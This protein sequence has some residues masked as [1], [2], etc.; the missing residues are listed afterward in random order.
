MAGITPFDYAAAEL[1]IAAKYGKF[2]YNPK[3]GRM[4]TIMPTTLE[5]PSKPMS[6]ETKNYITL[7]QYN[8]NLQLITDGINRFVADGNKE[9]EELKT[10]QCDLKAT[11]EKSIIATQG[12]LEDLKKEVLTQRPS[13]ANLEINLITPSDTTQIQIGGQHHMFPKLLKAIANKHNI[14]MVGPTGTGKT[15]GAE[16]AAKSLKLPCY[17]ITVNRETSQYQ[18]MGH[19]S[20]GE[21]HPGVAYKPYVDGGVLLVNE[22]DNGNANANTSIKTLTD[23]DE[24]F[25]PCGLVKRHPDFRLIATANTT[26]TGANMQYI[27]RN[28]QDKALLNIFKFLPWEIDE[29]FEYQICW[30]EWLSWGGVAEKKEQIFDPLIR[31]IRLIRQ[32]GE[33]LAINHIFSPRNSKFFFRDIATGVDVNEATYSI[34]FREL[35]KDSVDKIINHVKKNKKPGGLP[36]D[37][38]SKA[39]GS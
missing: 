8:E 34:L 19:V 13:S 26:G 39:W 10:K 21:Y 28:Q 29:A 9:I 1:E 31:E 23:S 12:M 2:K 35:T 15:T 20:K 11:V 22:L 17:S 14:Y 36:S 37:M 33:A 7:E 3:T 4:E 18:F 32:A 30:A 38:I 24:T 5:T 16:I 6:K 25:F 27:G